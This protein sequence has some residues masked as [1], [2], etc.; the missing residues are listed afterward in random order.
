MKNI[1]PN[2]IQK[3]GAIPFIWLNLHKYDM[4]YD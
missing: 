2:T 3:Y 4:E 1:N